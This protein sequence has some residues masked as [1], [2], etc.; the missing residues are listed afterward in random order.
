MNNVSSLKLLCQFTLKFGPV[1]S[2][3]MFFLQFLLE[4]TSFFKFYL[5]LTLETIEDQ[6]SETNAMINE[7][8]ETV[9]EDDIEIR[10]LIKNQQDTFENHVNDEFNDLKEKV[11]DQGL[12][13]IDLKSAFDDLKVVYEEE[14]TNLKKL[15]K[16]QSE[17]NTAQKVTLNT[18]FNSLK[19][20]VEDHAEEFAKLND[21]IKI[22]HSLPSQCANYKSLTDPSRRFDF[23]D[24][25]VKSD[26]SKAF[27]DKKNGYTHKRPTSDDWVGGSWYRI[28]GGAGTK[29]SEKGYDWVSGGANDGT[30]GTHW[31]SHMIGGHPNIPG[32]TENRSVCHGL[33]CSIQKHTIEVTNCNG[34][35]VYKL[36]GCTTCSFRYCT[37]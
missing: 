1:Q 11:E 4:P 15:I 16:E 34:F 14:H 22:N 31:G 19:E 20:E 27:C 7:L 26:S 28:Q 30:C 35:F 18:Q 13:D 6:I 8:K 5:F 17:L 3:E 2:C 24:S 37:Q 21:T 12:K 10:K 33:S 32:Q 9:Q 36:V 25:T 23:I 29:L